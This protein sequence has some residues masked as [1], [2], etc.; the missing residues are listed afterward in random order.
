MTPADTGSYIARAAIIRLMS[1]GVVAAETPEST[2]PLAMVDSNGAEPSGTGHTWSKGLWQAVQATNCAR[3]PM[4]PG[5]APAP[6]A[7]LTRAA[8][9]AT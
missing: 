6:E 2:A 7:P 9:L 1:R 8:F 3:I 5:A 4:A